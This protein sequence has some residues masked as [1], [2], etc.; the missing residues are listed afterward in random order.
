MKI[1]A[2]IRLKNAIIRERRRELGLTQKEVG[3]IAGVNKFQVSKLECFIP[4]SEKSIKKIALAL[5]LQPHEIISTLPKDVP[6]KFSII[7]EVSEQELEDFKYQVKQRALEYTNDPSENI[8][9]D[10]R[11]KFINEMLKALT[12]RERHILQLRFGI[13]GDRHTLEETAR[14]F[15]VTRERVR[16]IEIK[17]IRRLRERIERHPLKYLLEDKIPKL[18][19]NS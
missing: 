14:K 7:K 18:A 16:Q 2:E 15:K 17:A 8:M 5:D 9:E 1:E 13:D 11:Q 12:F 6:R 4:I 19:E 10:E 3:D